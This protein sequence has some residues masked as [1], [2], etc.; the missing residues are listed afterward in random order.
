MMS[1]TGGLGSAAI[2]TYKRLAFLGIQVGSNLQRHNGLAQ[3]QNLLLTIA[4]LHPSYPR[5]TLFHW[6][7]CKS[8]KACCRPNDSRVTDFLLSNFCLLYIGY[9]LWS[10]CVTCP[11]PNLLIILVQVSSNAIYEQ[12]KNT[13][14][15][16]VWYTYVE[17]CTSMQG[18]IFFIEEKQYRFH[19]ANKNKAL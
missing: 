6:T 7:C 5:C 9:L 14:S 16:V 4:F 10:H 3:M 1:S 8:S 15:Y 18:C 12:Q 19:M 2:V 11:I 17:K 13:T